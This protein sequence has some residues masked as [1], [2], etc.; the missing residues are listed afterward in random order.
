MAVSSRPSSSRGPWDPNA[1]HGGAPAAL[2]MR[3]FER[4]PA[5]AGLRSLA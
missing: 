4:L 1:L 2:L 5:A 3:E